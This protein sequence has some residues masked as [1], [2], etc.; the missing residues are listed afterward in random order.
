MSDPSYDDP[1]FE[2]T[3]ERYEVVYRGNL[4]YLPFACHLADID[5]AEEEERKAA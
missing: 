1:A 2:A 5:E 4:I 3:E